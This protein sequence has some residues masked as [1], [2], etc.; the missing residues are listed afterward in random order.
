MSKQNGSSSGLSYKELEF[1]KQRVAS[2]LRIDK[3]IQSFEYDGDNLI[4][5]KITLRLQGYVY[6]MTVAEKEITY[7]FDKP[8]FL[9]WLLGRRKSKTIKI[10]IADALKNPPI[11]DGCERLY[12]IE[13][14]N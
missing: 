8:S 13:K 2:I 6:Q 3:D 11:T 9:D 5:N 7:H 10:N 1:Q 4:K 12:T 14:I